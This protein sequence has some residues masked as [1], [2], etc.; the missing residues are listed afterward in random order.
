MK[1][2]KEFFTALPWQE[3]IPD[4]SHSILTAGFGAKGTFETRVSQSDYATAAAT[5]DGSFVVIYMPTARTV[6]IK[7]PAARSF[8]RAR[9]FDPTNGTYQDIPRS[10]FAKGSSEQF[11]PSDRN[12][13]G[14]SDW[15]LLLDAR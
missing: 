8:R 12:H 1:V 6:T 9:W 2:W 4:Q 13:D 7:M 11:T 5:A 10:H 14:D 15:V 3:L